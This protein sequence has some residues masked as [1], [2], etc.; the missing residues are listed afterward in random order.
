MREEEE[1]EY[2]EDKLSMMSRTPS[3][4]DSGTENGDN[5]R[6]PSPEIGE[7]DNS[8]PASGHEG[9]K[10]RNSSVE[11]RS[12]TRNSTAK[13][14]TP[15]PMKD[16]DT[17]DNND[18]RVSSPKETAESKASLSLQ[19]ENVGDDRSP[20]NG[21][22]IQTTSR[23]N[24]KINEEIENSKETQQS[25]SPTNTADNVKDNESR[26]S[27]PAKTAEVNTSEAEDEVKSVAD[28][29]DDNT[30]RPPTSKS[31]TETKSRG[32][33][34]NPTQHEENGFMH[35]NGSR[36]S[37]HE[38]E[39]D[40][41]PATKS[42]DASPNEDTEEKNNENSRAISAKKSITP[43]PQKLNDDNEGKTNEKSEE[44]GDDKR[45]SSA[46]SGT[47]NSSAKRVNNSRA[48]SRASAGRTSKNSP[49]LMK[50]ATILRTP[51][52]PNDT[53]DGNS[54]ND[55][56][57]FPPASRHFETKTAGSR[58]STPEASN[59]NKKDEQE[60]VSNKVSSAKIR[61]ETRNSQPEKSNPSPKDN[62]QRVDKSEV[63]SNRPVTK[64]PAMSR[65]SSRKDSEAAEQPAAVEQERTSRGNSKNS[66]K[67]EI[68]KETADDKKDEDTKT[69]TPTPPKASRG[70]S[71]SRK[72]PRP[73]SNSRPDSPQNESIS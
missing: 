34:E 73:K 6:T 62:S 37:L 28:R 38:Y 36:S 51:S 10:S 61:T 56:N 30:S 35:K 63:V 16:N 41:D 18:S 2:N 32:E 72:S 46:K 27:S 48:S 43:S 40:N 44:Y 15:S 8:R 68:S 47:R 71:T 31:R 58:V 42:R 26:T 4:N 45:V 54:S 33:L 29:E 23:Q 53:E 12:E 64:S 67:D 66:L 24:N 70:P 19:T 11:N 59:Q 5:P 17:N 3:P 25:S 22:E 57:S 52:P 60:E 20:A 7:K 65:P 21:D 55:E 14:R 50:S 9:N 39:V 49:R 13:S 1:E 69:F